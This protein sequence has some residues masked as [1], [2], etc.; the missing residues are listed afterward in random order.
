MMFRDEFFAFQQERLSKIG[1]GHWWQERGECLMSGTDTLDDNNEIM[2]LGLNPGGGRDGSELPPLKEQVAAFR[3]RR[4]GPFSTYLDECWHYSKKSEG[5]E[6]WPQ[7]TCHRC[8]QVE[9]STTDRSPVVHQEKHQK[10]VHLIATQLAFDLRRTVALNAFWVQTPDA[11]ALARKASE[12]KACLD[13]ADDVKPTVS[14]LFTQVYFPIIRELI[15]GAKIKRIICLGN[16]RYLSPF[17][18]LADAYGVDDAPWKT[19]GGRT[20][21][22]DGRSFRHGELRV[23]GIPH[24]SMHSLS[25]T[26]IE[27]IK[28]WYLDE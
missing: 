21:Y 28:Q 19:A 3:M 5:F 23:F 16:G 4:T 20:A 11:L 1:G 2:I 14:H 27:K 8:L 22:L 12:S 7:T 6:G 10:N 24:P 25:A 18:L 26:G 15:R 17:R 9:K 13:L